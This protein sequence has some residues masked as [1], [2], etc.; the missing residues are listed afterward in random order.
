MTWAKKAVKQDPDSATV[1]LQAGYLAF[2]LEDPQQALKYLVKAEE[3]NAVNKFLLFMLMASIYLDAEETDLAR[4]YV[5]TLIADNSENAAV[6]NL[7]AR[8]RLAT[9]ELKQA[10]QHVQAAVDGDPS[11][12]DFLYTK[13]KVLLESNRAD[14]AESVV[15]KA[16]GMDAEDLRF[17]LEMFWQLTPN[18]A[19]RPHYKHLLERAPDHPLVVRAGVAHDL[20]TDDVSGSI[21][22]A[23]SIITEDYEEDFH[24]D[25]FAGLAAFYGQ[26]PELLHRTAERL[27]RGVEVPL[28]PQ[29][30]WL[31][32]AAARVQ[33]EPPDLDRA[34]ELLKQLEGSNEILKGQMEEDDLGRLFRSVWAV[35]RGRFHYWK[36]DDDTR[37]LERLQEA[38]YL[39]ESDKETADSEAPEVLD[40]LAG[41]DEMIAQ[42]GQRVATERVMESQPEEPVEHVSS[43]LPGVLEAANRYYRLLAGHNDTLDLSRRM[44]EVLSEFDQPLLVTVVGEFN[45]GKSTF[46]NAMLGESIAPMDV[47]PTTATIN[48]L[49]Y[50]ED[51]HLRIVFSDGSIQ[52]GGLDELEQ[53]AKET[54]DGERQRMLRKIDHVEIFYPMEALKKINIVDTPGLNALIEEHQQITESFIEKSDAVLWLFRADVAGKESERTQL[55]FLLR[56]QKKTIG[57]VNQIDLVEDEDEVED[58]L[59]N[60][61]DGFGSYLSEV[62]GI[63]ARDALEGRQKGDAKLL[64]WSNFAQLEELITQRFTDQ[65]RQIKQEATVGKIGMVHQDV[66]G[67]QDVLFNSKQQIAGRSKDLRDSIGQF[68]ERFEAAHQEEQQKFSEELSG[69]LRGVCKEAAATFLKRGSGGLMDGDVSGFAEETY[70]RVSGVFEASW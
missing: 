14:E 9:G 48:L 29:V 52:E 22:K 25:L 7:T 11:D 45:V 31:F 67:N 66:A 1:L 34:E 39:F 5:E 42:L 26:E 43:S 61:R 49:K 6:H 24:L 17:P 35:T 28:G 27:Q 69:A 32:E 8:L 46:I 56:N 54:E 58:V 53:F 15:R 64:E 4:P 18:E 55:E 10:E 20:F 44:S 57:V 47:V 12:L 21:S 13:L 38:K 65:A 60:V 23:H 2:M 59:Q 16:R 68:R 37:A 70:R 40:L 33:D 36:G 41:I 30:G 62:V 50:G 51:R 63:S 19:C 3:R